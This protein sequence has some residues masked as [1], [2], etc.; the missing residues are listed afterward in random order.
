MAKK[1]KGAT[2]LIALVCS[3]TGL[4][5]YTTMKNRRAHPEKLELMKYCPKLRK[6]TLH[7]E[8][9]IK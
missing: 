8:G 2:E 7:R 9:K 1:S 3:E 5:N 6:H 4:R